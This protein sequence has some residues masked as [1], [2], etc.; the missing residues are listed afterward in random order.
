[1]RTWARNAVGAA[2]VALAIV[3]CNGGT[4][5][6][7]T[8]TPQ[9]SALGDCTQVANQPVSY[10]VQLC[11][12]CNQIISACDVQVAG[13]TIF[14]DP[15]V[16]TCDATNSCPPACAQNTSACSFTAPPTPDVYVV[17]AFDPASNQTRTGTLTVVASGPESCSF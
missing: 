14:L 5:S 16:E 7:P 8:E 6:C 17:E 4:G 9:V 15:R 13:N 2:A 3:G 10:P 1:M 11:P 12:T